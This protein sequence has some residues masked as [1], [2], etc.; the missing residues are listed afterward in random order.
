MRK[1]VECTFG[2]LKGRFRILKTG[3]RLQSFQAVDDI[4]FTCCALHNLFEV[5]GLHKQWTKGIPSDYEN[6]L[7]QHDNYDTVRSNLHPEIFRRL[8]NPLLYDTTTPVLNYVHGEES[9][10]LSILNIS[11]E[12]MRSKLVENFHYGWLNKDIKWPSRNGVIK[13]IELPLMQC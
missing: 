13:L 10:D 2:I 7:G 12:R 6:R 4:W 9:E 11:F 3:I 1:D 8:E 5:D